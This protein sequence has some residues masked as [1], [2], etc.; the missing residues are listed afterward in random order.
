MS[1]WFDISLAMDPC[2]ICMLQG[3]STKTDWYVLTG[4]DSEPELLQHVFHCLALICKFMVKPI[5]SDLPTFL[6][7]SASLRYYKAEHI[8][9]LSAATFSHLLRHCTSLQLKQAV[10]VLFAGKFFISLYSKVIKNFLLTKRPF[11][12]V[13]RA[14]PNW[15]SGIYWCSNVVSRCEISH[16]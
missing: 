7:N 11:S 12:L 1:T 2:L 6:K 13:Q 15:S 4:G 16:C 8:R 10:R 9:K 3:T 5:A 14:I